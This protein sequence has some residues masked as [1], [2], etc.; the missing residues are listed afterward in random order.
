VGA[1]VLKVGTDVMTAVGC[2]ITVQFLFK[3]C[4]LSTERLC[5]VASGI[6]KIPPWIVPLRT[7]SPTWLVAATIN[8]NK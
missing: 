1:Q 7:F 3:C 4:S 6:R 2:Q 5:V 8:V